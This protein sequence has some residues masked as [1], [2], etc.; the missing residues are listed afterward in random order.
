MRNFEFLTRSLRTSKFSFFVLPRM[1]FF[2]RSNF[3]VNAVK[4][5]FR[6]TTLSHSTVTPVL[7]NTFLTV[8]FTPLQ[9]MKM[10]IMVFPLLKFHQIITSLT[11]TT[12]PA[13]GEE[14]PK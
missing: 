12:S 1:K 9:K 4:Q 2:R 14:I 5:S 8:I 10:E 13:D 7:M 3:S 11:L 6:R